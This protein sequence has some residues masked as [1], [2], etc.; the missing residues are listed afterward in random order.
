MAKIT[1]DN[2]EYDEVKLSNEAKAQLISLRFV[3]AELARL[4]AQAAAYQ[5]ARNAYASALKEL[6]PKKSKK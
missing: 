5:T 2:V 3:D 4:N 6:L 1:I